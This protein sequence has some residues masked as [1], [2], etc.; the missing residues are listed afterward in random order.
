MV[1][2]ALPP[3]C[4]IDMRIIQ[5]DERLGEGFQANIQ[6]QKENTLRVLIA[7]A[8]RAARNALITR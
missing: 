8:F 5:W 7:T 1:L 3:K 6:S 4:W 2:N